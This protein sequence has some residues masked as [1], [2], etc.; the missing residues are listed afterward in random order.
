M[1]DIPR[2]LVE[3]VLKPD[4]NSDESDLTVPDLKILEPTSLDTG[5]SVGFDPYDTGVLQKK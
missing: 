3:S 2:W 5:E 4:K 1:K